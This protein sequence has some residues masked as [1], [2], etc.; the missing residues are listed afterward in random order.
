VKI[1]PPKAFKIKEILW[2]PPLI[3]WTKCNSDGVA[4]GSLG[5]ASCGGVFGWDYQSIYFLVC[6][7][8]NIDVSFALHVELM[9][10]MLAT[11]MA[12]DR[13]DIIFD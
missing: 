11:E 12:F 9:R 3:S 13:V 10:V 8:S 6:Y 7:V 2:Y 5:N 1:L 4:H